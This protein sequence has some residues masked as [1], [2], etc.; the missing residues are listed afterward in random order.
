MCVK[1][2]VMVTGVKPTTPQPFNDMGRYCVSQRG[3][4]IQLATSHYTTL[5]LGEQIVIAL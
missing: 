3:S 1:E 2:G 4:P 5:K